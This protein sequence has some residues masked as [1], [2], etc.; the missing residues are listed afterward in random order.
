MTQD[1]NQKNRPTSPHLQIYR[2]NI[3][4]ITSIMHRFTGVALY[5]SIIAISWY[6]VFYTYQINIAEPTEACDCPYAKIM[7]CIFSAAVIA[8]T[9]ALYYHFC[10]GVRHLFWDIGKGFD[11]KTA[12]SNGYLVITLSLVFTALTIGTALYL[13]LF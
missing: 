5:F 11:K 10:N 12:Q 1:I 3:T 8:L 2:W 7:N 6:V 4:S 9:F 13:K